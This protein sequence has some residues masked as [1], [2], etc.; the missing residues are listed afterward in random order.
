MTNF[1]LVRLF[2]LLV[3]T[4]LPIF[5]GLPGDTLVD[6]NRLNGGIRS[7]QVGNCDTALFEISGTGLVSC[8]AIIPASTRPYRIDIKS[9][10]TEG[11]YVDNHI[12]LWQT[13]QNRTVYVEANVI[14]MATGMRKDGKIWVVIAVVFVLFGSVLGYLLLLQK[15]IGSIELKSRE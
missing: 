3:S 2:F 1:N 7:F 14:E 13:E 8:K 6:L 10:T 4:P 5:A 12:E 15:K 11:V 9:Q